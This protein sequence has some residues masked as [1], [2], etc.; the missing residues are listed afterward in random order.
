[1]LGA[2]GAREKSNACA[3]LRARIRRGSP[4]L[5]SMKAGMEVVSRG[6]LSTSPL[7]A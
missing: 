5:R 7:R 4:Q 3:K 1:M 2:R 6:V